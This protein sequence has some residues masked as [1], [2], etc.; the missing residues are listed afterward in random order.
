G[1]QLLFSVIVLG[2]SIGLLRGQGPGDEGYSSTPITIRF[3]VFVGAI[4]L[5][6]GFIGV[7]AEWVSAL[8]GKIMLVIDGIITVINIAGGVVS[9]ILHLTSNIGNAKC[10]DTSILNQLKLYDNDLFN[11]GC[12]RIKTTDGGDVTVCSNDGGRAKYLNSRCKETQADSVFMFFT[13]AILLARAT[14]TYL[15]MKKGY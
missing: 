3:A 5:V 15:R 12:H 7:A 1:F 14:M 13:V 2:L 9:A 11:G 10:S 8:Q 6:T 4:S